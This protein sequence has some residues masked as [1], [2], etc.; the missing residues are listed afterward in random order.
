MYILIF[1]DIIKYDDLFKKINTSNTK[2]KVFFFLQESLTIEG[3][4]L[5]KAE[6]NFVSKTVFLFILQI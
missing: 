3:L 5:N 6:F 4:K 1:L 2:D